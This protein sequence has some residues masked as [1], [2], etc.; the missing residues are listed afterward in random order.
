MYH[1]HASNINII[2][3]LLL[4]V[5]DIWTGNDSLGSKEKSLSSDYKDGEA[6][7]QPFKCLAITRHND[8]GIIDGGVKVWE[9]DDDSSL[10]DYFNPTVSGRQ[11]VTSNGPVQKTI[12]SG[13]TNIDTDP[14]LASEG[15]NNNLAFNWNYGNNGARVVLTDVG[16]YSGT[17]SAI[18]ENDDDTHGLGNTF[19][20][21]YSEWTHDASILQPDCHGAGCAVQ[22]TD[23]GDSE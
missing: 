2:S 17:L 1:S 13:A 14:I 23:Y 8:D 20:F 16:K 11:V 3:V 9:M 21:L 22:G 19:D 18:D 15:T 7:Q 10:S 4:G 6:W 5:S 12:A